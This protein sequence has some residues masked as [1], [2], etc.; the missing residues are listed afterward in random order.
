MDHEAPD[1][2]PDRR[3]LIG[4]GLLV[5]V[6][7]ALTLAVA[8]A[9]VLATRSVLVGQITPAEAVE[10]YLVEL[11]AFA[12]FSYLL[13]RLTLAAVKR[14]PRVEEEADGEARPEAE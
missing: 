8:Y 14:G 1:G 12:L 4:V 7:P 3:W 6:T 5:V 9:V 13:Y 10:L 11:A 2:E